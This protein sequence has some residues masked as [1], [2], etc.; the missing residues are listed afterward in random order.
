[1]PLHVTL[2]I[3]CKPIWD[4]GYCSSP[5]CFSD[6]LVTSRMGL[7][8]KGSWFTFA[9][10]E[11]GGSASLALLNKGIK[12]WCV[13]IAVQVLFLTILERKAGI[14]IWKVKLQVDQLIYP[15]TIQERV[16]VSL[17]IY[18]H[19]P[20][21]LPVDSS[22]YL[23][24]IDLSIYQFIFLSFFLSFFLFFFLSV[25]PSIHFSTNP[26]ESSICF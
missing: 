16:S 11:I 18:K 3:P 4:F 2:Q 23:L 10:T 14:F 7:S 17:S 21:N 5:F 12:F 22:F 19:L 20:K 15:I 25:Y 13:W 8:I 9:Q 1:M 6:Q 26:N 24:F